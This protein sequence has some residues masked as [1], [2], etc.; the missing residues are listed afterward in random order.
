MHK[1]KWITW[2]VIRVTDSTTLWVYFVK[3]QS[4]AVCVRLVEHLIIVTSYNVSR[5]A[6]YKDVYMRTIEILQTHFHF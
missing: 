5:K 3:V 2:I 1:L 4:A 6:Q